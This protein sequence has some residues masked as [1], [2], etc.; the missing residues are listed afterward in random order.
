MDVGKLTNQ[1]LAAEVNRRNAEA[2]DTE[3]K[4]RKQFSQMLFTT[5]P[6]HTLIEALLIL[7]PDHSRTS[8]SDDNLANAYTDAERCPTG[9]CTRCVLMKAFKD[10]WWDEDLGIH[11]EIM[12]HCPIESVK[13]V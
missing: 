11:I 1:E 4:R 13:A 5:E 12:R 8:C 7:H 10:D 9:R 2:R 6:K 3:A